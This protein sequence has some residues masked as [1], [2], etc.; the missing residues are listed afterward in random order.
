MQGEDLFYVFLTSSDENEWVFMSSK[1]TFGG[2]SDD[3]N[4]G[5]LNTFENYLVSFNLA[6][7]GIGVPSEAF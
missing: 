3:Y 6:M 5:P 4:Y 1:F 2:K 7:E